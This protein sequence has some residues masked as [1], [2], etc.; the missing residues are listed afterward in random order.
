MTPDV[1]LELLA[2]DHARS[3]ERFEQVNRD[4]FAA[5][6]G[7]R[8]DD[9]F[10]R[11]DDRLA[12]RVDENR[13]GSSLYFVLVDEEAE[14][15]GRVN[16]SDIDQPEVTEIGFRVAEEAQGRGVATHG[17]IAALDIAAAKGVR[18]VMARVSTANP[19]SSR[20][21]ERCG[22]DR[23]GRADTP[24]GASGTFIHYRKQLAGASASP[25]SEAS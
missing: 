5:R 23:V 24:D 10:A 14:I 1:R 22:F 2:P 13:Q 4:F 20:V 16:I 25:D 12:A 15:V 6:V 17:V 7:D 21:L 9:F 8:G 3:L 18:A 11:F 19:S